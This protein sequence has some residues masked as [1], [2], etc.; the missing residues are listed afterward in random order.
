MKK[1]RIGD[2]LLRS[3]GGIR[4]ITG[5]TE[6]VFFLTAIF[7]DNIVRTYPHNKIIVARTN[8]YKKVEV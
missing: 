5:E 3:N 7:D 4:V 1:Y 2:V 6:K 8:L